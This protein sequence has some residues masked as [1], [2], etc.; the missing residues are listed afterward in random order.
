M[1]EKPREEVGSPKDSPSIEQTTKEREENTL[2][3]P[4][5]YETMSSRMLRGNIELLKK[6]IEL[7]KKVLPNLQDEED[8]TA[9]KER[10]AECEMEI[11]LF[12][13]ELQ[14][15]ESGEK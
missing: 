14:K 15:K 2:R 9:I 7:D 5:Y 4:H 3:E 13:N 1:V 10:I 11:E 12:Q 6:D 8:I